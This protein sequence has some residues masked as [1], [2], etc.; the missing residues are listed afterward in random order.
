MQI[1]LRTNMADYPNTVALKQGRVI[2]D[3]VKLDF[4]SAPKAAHN[5]FKPMIRDHAFDAGELAIVTYLQA[6]AIGKPWI[7]LPMPVL[8][9]HQ[10]HCIGFNRELVRLN[11]KDIE[12]KKVG[13]RSYAQT[14]GLWVRGILKHEYGV[15]IDKVQW[16]TVDEGHLSEYR[17]P[18]NSER[19]PAGSSLAEMMLSGELAAAVL[20]QEM[21]KD[22][23]ISTLIPDSHAASH[24]WSE[25]KGV[26]PINH[27]FVVHERITAEHPDVVR[28]IYRM[29]MESR[30]QAPAEALQTLPAP[31]LEANRK[32]LQLAI[33]W[34][35]EQKIINRRLSVDELFDETTAL[36]EG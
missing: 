13:I 7:M 35:L 11:P 6:R 24:Q 28:E 1:T 34:A 27:V 19:L 29:L 12:G 14:T 5:G 10:H 15:D 31:G 9:R 32:G 22:D 17:D 21:P 3:I 33:D 20:G 2:S 26:I 8:G 16:M 23:R 18:P 30:A 25:R 36:V 4:S